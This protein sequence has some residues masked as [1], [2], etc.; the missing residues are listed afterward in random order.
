MCKTASE[1]RAVCVLCWLVVCIYT[2]H[3]SL[4]HGGTIIMHVMSVRLLY[5]CIMYIYRAVGRRPVG[6]VG[7]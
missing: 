6:Y 3:T 5:S 7:R 1:C 2:Q 4:V